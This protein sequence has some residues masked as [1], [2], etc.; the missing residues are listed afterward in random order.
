M[1]TQRGKFLVIGAI[2]VVV[3]LVA[4]FPARIAYHWIA[5]PGMAL[6]AIRGTVWSGHAGE[7]MVEGVYV[8]DVSWSF[9]PLVLFRGKVAFAI[10]AIP[11]AGFIETTVALGPSGSAH[12]EDLQGSLPL[13]ILE[14]PA[15]LPGLRGN[16][17][18]QFERLVIRG[19]LPV[20]ADGVL[21]VS[22]LTAPMI[23]RGSIGGYRVEFFT[24]NSG[25]VASVEDTDGVVDIAGSFEVGS[26]RKYQF[27]AQLAPKAATPDNLRQQMQYLGSPNERGQ[28]QLRLEGVL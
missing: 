23:Y 17:S 22:G 6:N 4:M 1:K 3:G 20:A 25:V 2:T 27:I 9:K 8:R 24:Q 21:T 28:Y 10:N 26:D 12:F 15:R 14:G 18:L 13:E 5:P 19:G 16:A 7:G 11:G